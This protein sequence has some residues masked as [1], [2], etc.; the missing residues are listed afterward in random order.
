MLWELA[1]RYTH[2]LDWGLISRCDLTARGRGLRN[3]AGRCVFA[4]P[5]VGHQPMHERRYHLRGPD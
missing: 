2:F 5:M 3:F 4:R 1:P